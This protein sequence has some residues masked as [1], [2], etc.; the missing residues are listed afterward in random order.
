MPCTL[1]LRLEF[2]FDSGAEDTAMT[3]AN[4]GGL[5]RLLRVIAGLLLA[6]WAWQ[7]GFGTMGVIVGVIA[8]L[9]LV[10]GAV[11]F[12]PAYWLFGWSTRKAEV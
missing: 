4:E 3:F 5:D 10:T 6:Y 8:A 11:G 9:V 1:D 7:I 12:C 2:T